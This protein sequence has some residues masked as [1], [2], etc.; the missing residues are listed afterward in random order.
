MEYEALGLERVRELLIL[1]RWPIE[2]G[3][4]IIDIVTYKDR[5]LAFTTVWEATELKDTYKVT[6]QVSDGRSLKAVRTFT[7]KMEYLGLLKGEE[8][9][10]EY[11][12]MWV[13]GERPWEK[14][15]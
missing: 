14:V 8:G 13:D 11:I 10:V 12:N 5:K 3:D 2:P 4:P 1:P 7:A 9:E 6:V 15:D